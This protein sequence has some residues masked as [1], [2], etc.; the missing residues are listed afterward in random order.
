M[1]SEIGQGDEVI[2]QANG[3]IATM[4]GILHCGATPIFVEP[5]EYYQLDISHI[6]D[7]I[8][9]R[10][11]AVVLTHLYGQAT[12]MEPII[13]VCK[14]RGLKLF[15]DCAQAHFASYDDQYAGTFG[16]AAFFSFY[17]TKNMG[18]FGDGGA[19]VSKNKSTIEKVKILRN[20]GSDYRYHN[21]EVGYNMRLDEIQAA[22]LRVK[23]KHISE[24]LRNRNN[25]AGRY[26]KEISNHRIRLPQI[27]ERCNHTWYQYVVN[28]DDQE[29]FIEY[30]RKNGVGVDVMWRVPPY[31]QPAISQKYGYKRGDYPITEK[32]CS[33]MVSLPMMDYM[34]TEEID[35][36]IEAINRYEG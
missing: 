19:V 25:I 31:L 4:L 5:D 28:V 15:E 8:T 14:E 22:L 23:L 1:A 36:V 27:A 26:S 3:Y 17:P 12:R 16:D 24:L 29:G 2:M 32:I 30:M 10:T 9:A 20:Y 6:D 13:K 11:K 33:T 18:G 35:Y 21:V 34:T 7:V